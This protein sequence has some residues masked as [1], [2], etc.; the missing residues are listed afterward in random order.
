MFIATQSNHGHH[1]RTKTIMNL[2]I[3]HGV[4]VSLVA[5]I[6]FLAGLSG[7]GTSV[8]SLTKTDH[9]RIA[10]AK[11]SENPTRRWRS[12]IMDSYESVPSLAALAKSGNSHSRLAADAAERPAVLPSDISR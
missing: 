5:A 1:R 9:E 3:G 2:T 6:L 10:S 12:D 11:E 7:P 8:L 4:L